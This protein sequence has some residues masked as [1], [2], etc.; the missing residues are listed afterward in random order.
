MTDVY[1]PIDY[2]LV[3]FPSSSDT[4]GVVDALAD[5]VDR[6]VVRLYDLLVIRKEEDGTFSGVDLEDVTP[7]GV[8]SFRAFAGARSGLLNDDDLREAGNAMTPGTVAAF[9]VYENAWAVPF[10]GAASAAQGEVVAS[11]RIPAQDVMD[12]LDALE[13][14]S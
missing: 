7:D 1:G 4:S 11:A 10:V 3:E 2:L 14:T 13:S 5:L 6:G 12:A 8:G 9:L